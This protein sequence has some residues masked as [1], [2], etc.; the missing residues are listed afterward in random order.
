MYKPR[1]EPSPTVFIRGYI[2]SGHTLKYKQ[3]G[4]VKGLGILPVIHSLHFAEVNIILFV[5]IISTPVNSS[6]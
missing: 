1:P 4:E 3:Q 6:A 2:L 5:L